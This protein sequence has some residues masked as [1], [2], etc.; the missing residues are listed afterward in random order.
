MLCAIYRKIG[1]VTPHCIT[2]PIL[3][4]EARN[5]AGELHYGLASWCAAPSAPRLSLGTK[6][7]VSTLQPIVKFGN[8]CMSLHMVPLWLQECCRAL[9]SQRDNSLNRASFYQ[10]GLRDN[11]WQLR[12]SP[13]KCQGLRVSTLPLT[14]Q[15]VHHSKM[16]FYL[17]HCR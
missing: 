1:D 13:A 2:L 11:A 14:L 3:V 15:I 17:S 6:S 8:F 9:L 5:L 7:E 4:R 10:R 16:G 12:S